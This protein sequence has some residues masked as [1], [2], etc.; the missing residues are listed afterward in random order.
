MS[1]LALHDAADWRRALEAIDHDWYHTWDCHALASAQGEG[2]PVLLVSSQPDNTLV[3]PLLLRDL[4]GGQKDATSVY[5]YAGPVAQR[6]ASDEAVAAF[7]SDVE[8]WCRQQE[9]IAVFSR[10]HPLFNPRQVRPPAGITQHAGT[11]IAIDLT[12][13][14]EAQV[15]GIRNNHRRGIRKLE[16]NGARCVNDSAYL[17]AFVG[18]YE[19]TMARLDASRY[20]FFSREYYASLLSATD[21]ETRVYTVLDADGQ[22]MCSGLFVVTPTVVQYHLGGTAG[23][24]FK[25]APAKL[26]MEQVRRDGAR[27]GRRYFHLGGGLGGREDSL[28]AFKRGFSDL[29]LD[30][31]LLKW[32]IDDS[33][34]EERVA[35]CR[36]ESGDA[37]FNED[38]FPAYRQTAHG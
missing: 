26:M 14:E 36:R 34:Y 12:Q 19:E 6:V 24:F 11:T 32:V 38:F 31:S 30:F 9:V 23:Q 27:E 5:G 22:A 1:L 15:R 3:M 7:F 37:P 25:H 21:F 8:H 29:E 18:I 2:Q 13:T 10:L 33:A 17:D 35:R 20:Y 4:D 28:F 16:R